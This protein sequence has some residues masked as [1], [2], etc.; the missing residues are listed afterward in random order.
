MPPALNR[1]FRPSVSR[2]GRPYTYKSSEAKRWQKDAGWL[3]IAARGAN[4]TF[5]G[6]VRVD[7]KLLVK[8][9]RDIDSSFKLL[10]DALED[11]K[12]I[13]NDRQITHLCAVKE[14]SDRG[15]VIVNVTDLDSTS[16]TD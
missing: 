9:D 16:K 5:E 4:P 6:N 13:K 15:I 2:G 8:R 11:A 7:L 3:L 12:V 1:A 14:K 10:L